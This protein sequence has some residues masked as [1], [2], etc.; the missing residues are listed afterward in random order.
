[1][2][3]NRPMRIFAGIAVAAVLA[4]CAEEQGRSDRS[5]AAGVTAETSM[6]RG[7]EVVEAN[8]ASC[9]AP[10]DDGQLSRISEQRK[11]PE[12]WDMTIARMIVAHGLEISPEDRRVAVKYLADNYGLAPEE[13]AGFRYALERRPQIVET[14]LLEG[15]VD[16]R[17]FVM[18][19]R[20]HSLARVGL[21][22]RDA[23][24]W[25]LLV[26]QHVGQWPTIE[27]H[28]LSRDR[29]WLD[30]ATGWVA[31]LL[32]QQYGH[33][34]NAWD[35]WK[36]ADKA[37]PAG[38][39]RV[40]S[41]V[42]G[43]GFRAQD[44]EVTAAGNDLFELRGD[45]A[46]R[47]M[48]YNGYEWR[49][50]GSEDYRE[51]AALSADGTTLV[52]RWFHNDRPETGGV[53]H[54]VRSDMGI[55]RILAVSTEGL[56]R[57]GSTEITI[58]G[59]GLAGD[60]DLGPGVQ[61]EPVKATSDEIV[62]RV[63]VAADAPVGRRDL[64]IGNALLADGIAIYDRIDR[65]VV[66]PDY[67]VS[68]VGGG[69]TEPVATQFEAVAF[70]NGADGKPDTDDDFRIGVVSAEWKTG[71]FDESAAE[72]KDAQFAGEITP[73]GLFNPAPAGPNPERRYGTGNFGDLTITATVDDAGRKV[74]GVAR[75]I[76]SAQR[77]NNPP[78]Y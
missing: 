44:M 76:V 74:S 11:T 63:T 22:R 21:Q 78:I 56:R 31:D 37:N 62:A 64:R 39:W 32:G 66:T 48:I 29:D 65:V 14:D 70:H 49:G 77:W 52:G 57:G 7:Q 9:H 50:R 38:Q 68:R 40:V 73:T 13:A 75:L 17:L 36:A 72:M 19:G 6:M 27:Y 16:E 42:P 46:T 33:S 41:Y 61:V 54:A 20:C 3:F 53:L 58:L 5:G 18:C 26:N 45:R 60:L 67:A 43:E 2:A 59:T 1:M 69:N 10:A 51:V 28:M 30:E 8:C 23:E 24:E 47:A 35:A 15:D 71:P 25:R 55:E 12:G 4:A 34:S